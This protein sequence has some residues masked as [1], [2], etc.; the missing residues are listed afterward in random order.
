[1]SIGMESLDLIAIPQGLKP[2]AHCGIC[3]TTEV[4]P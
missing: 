1:M 3:G 4:V 2:S